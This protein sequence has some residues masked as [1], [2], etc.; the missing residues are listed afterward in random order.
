MRDY[1]ESQVYYNRTYPDKIGENHYWQP[2]G[3]LLA[4]SMEVYL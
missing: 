1:K 4:D 3:G 2:A